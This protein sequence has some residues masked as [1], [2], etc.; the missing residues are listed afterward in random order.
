MEGTTD[1]DAGA[2]IRDGMKSVSNQ[3]VCPESE[4]D[5]D[6][7][8]FTIKPTDQCYQDALNNKITSYQRITQN[9]NQMKGCLASGYPFVLGIS[10]YE[11]F[12]SDDVAK[13]GVVPMPSTLESQLGGHAI[14]CVGYNDDNQ[15]FIIRNSW[16]DTWGDKGYFFLPYT[17]VLD[18]NLAADFWTIRTVE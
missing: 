17:Y 15:Q 11:S 14:M 13:T 5:Y 7:T 8:K 6:T 10:I 1:D 18:E 9:L 16:G 3:G 12:E 2:E 4:W